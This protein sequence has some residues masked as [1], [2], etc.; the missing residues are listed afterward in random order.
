MTRQTGT[1][2]RSPAKYP[3]PMCFWLLDSDNDKPLGVGKARELAAVA[4]A[5]E[6]ARLLQL[7]DQGQAFVGDAAVAGRRD[8]GI[9]AESLG[10]QPDTA[11]AS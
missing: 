5:E 10:G 3:K 6:I 1:G 7:A 11:G 8:R 9:G 4:C 2:C